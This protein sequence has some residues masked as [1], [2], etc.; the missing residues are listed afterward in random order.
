MIGVILTNKI[1]A[2]GCAT[3]FKPISVFEYPRDSRINESNGIRVPS[4]IPII[5]AHK[6]KTR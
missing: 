3:T 6:N 1:T 4:F 5:K 2:K